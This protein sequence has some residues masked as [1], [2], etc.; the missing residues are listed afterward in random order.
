MAE[1]MTEL[2]ELLDRLVREAVTRAIAEQTLEN[3][4]PEPGHSD[5]VTVAEAAQRLA[6]SRSTIYAM[7]ASGDLPY[8]QIGAKRGVTVEDLRLY[9]ERHR[10]VGPEHRQR[11]NSAGS[12]PP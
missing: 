9:V 10:A 1:T 7:M 5:L 3:E 4:S 12:G 2:A 6:V 8:V 11:H